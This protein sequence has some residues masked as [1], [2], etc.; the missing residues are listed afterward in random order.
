MSKILI[1][2]T[3]PEDWKGLLAEPEKQWK[4]GYS[5]RSLAH[6]WENA[7]GF[8]PEIKDVLTQV[9]SLEGIRPLLIL[10]EWKV[11]LP[12]GSTE[13]QN[14]VWVLAKR[15]SGLI[16]IAIEGK[17][18]ESFSD[19]VGIWKKD[20]SPGKLKR[21]AYL[22]DTLAL[23]EPIPDTIYYQLLHR[24]A[25]AVIE[26]ERFGANQA[27]MLVHSFSPTNKWL[28][29]FQEYVRLYGVEAEIG[30]PVTVSARSG[31][32]LHLAWVHG[33][34]KFLQA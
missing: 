30:R 5:A 9:P 32:P 27:V 15:E 25:S 29:E 2:T 3:S 34:E 33:D 23:P 21:L 7:D 31:I 1:P 11:P 18:E 26:A 16:S 24:T 8:P 14:D 12:G 6:C 28:P 10:P 19:P 22:A 13:S 20:A 4:S 17:V